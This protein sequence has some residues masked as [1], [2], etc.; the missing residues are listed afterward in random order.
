MEN[1]WRSFSIRKAAHGF[2]WEIM[3]R[4][5]SAGLWC[6]VYLERITATRFR[7][8]YLA[9]RSVNNVFSELSA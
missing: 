4:A 9:T 3:P 7:R 1:N 8:V 2:G 6:D 5:V